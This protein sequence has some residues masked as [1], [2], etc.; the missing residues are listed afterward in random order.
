MTVNEQTILMIGVLLIG[1]PATLS[2]LSAL[3]EKYLD[4]EEQEVEEKHCCCH[5]CCG[6]QQCAIEECGCCGL[7]LDECQCEHECHNH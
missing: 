3:W 7:P 6:C 4:K 2:V 1:I 5:E